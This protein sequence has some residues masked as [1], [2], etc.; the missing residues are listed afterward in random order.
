MKARCVIK[1]LFLVLSAAAYVHGADTGAVAYAEGVRAARRGDDLA[2]LRAFDMAAEAGLDTA[3]LQYNRGVTLLRLGR[4]DEAESALRRA[5]ADP[6]LAAL[7]HWHLGRIARDARRWP[8]ARRRFRLA[9]AGASSDPLR[10]LAER[11]EAAL[12]PPPDRSLFLELATGYDSAAGFRDEDLATGARTGDLFASLW[13]SGEGMLLG[14]RQSGLRLF[15][16][17]ALTLF[18]RE[19]D[20]NLALLEAGAGL[21]HPPA[22]WR[23]DTGLRLQHVRA[24]AHSLETAAEI[25]AAGSRRLFPDEPASTTR[26]HLRGRVCRIEGGA[27]YGHLDGFR[28][29]ARVRVSGRHGTGRWTADI[30]GEFNDRADRKTEDSFASASPV[31]CQIAAGYRAHATPSLTAEGNAS[32]RVSL[33][34]GRDTLEDGSHR[35]RRDRRLALSGA[36]RYRNNAWPWIPFLRMDWNDNSSNIP[37]HAYDRFRLA[38]GA[39]RAW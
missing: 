13:M 16:A 6:A 39:D 5:T 26:L 33:F 11:A 32:W 2:A 28:H 10:I 20:A 7:A 12:P 17:G 15:G 29:D 30:Q 23:T 34:R 1:A 31:R 36:M 4:R 24:G 21:C 18:A 35:A 19:S 37:V 27:R 22:G 38:L 3:R 9:A 8:E 25:R 14:N